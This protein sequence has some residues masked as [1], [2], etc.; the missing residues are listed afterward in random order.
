MCC[1][2]TFWRF[3]FASWTSVLRTAR[4]TKPPQWIA[5]CHEQ[6]RRPCPPRRQ[7]SLNTPI[8]SHRLR[9]R[10][11]RRRPRRPYR[12]RWWMEGSLCTPRST[13][14]APWTLSW[15]GQEV[16]GGRWLRRTRKCTIPRSR[17][18]L[19]RSGSCWRRW[20]RGRSLTRRRG[21]GKLLTIDFGRGRVGS[22]Q[23]LSSCD[24]HCA[25]L[26]EVSTKAV[27]DG[28]ISPTSVMFRPDKL[29]GYFI[30]HQI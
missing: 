28:N 25:V 1:G 8:S 3:N 6:R 24:L 14:N 13:S 11:R 12:L 27:R 9:G 23:R 16:R 10:R 30:Y 5:R 7:I 15:C 4:W 19:E 18:D 17:R 21:W 29:S 2:H 20:R 22:G 26:T